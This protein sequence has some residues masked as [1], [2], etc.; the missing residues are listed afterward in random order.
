M[1]TFNET[2]WSVLL[3]HATVFISRGRLVGDLRLASVH[4]ITLMSSD[5]LNLRH[6]A[7]TLLLVGASDALA[8]GLPGVSYDPRTKQHRAEG[9]HY[10]A[11]VEKLRANQ[12]DYTDEARS[13]QP[14]ACSLKA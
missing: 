3:L 5:P 14:I 9:R 11:V 6:D 2:D 13:W 4:S 1:G 12:V 10:R 7:G 8:S